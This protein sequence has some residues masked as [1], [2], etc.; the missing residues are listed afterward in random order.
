MWTLKIL[1]EPIRKNRSIGSF[2]FRLFNV[3]GS[4]GLRYTMCKD[5][6]AQIDCRN[7]KCKLYKG[8]GKCSNILPTITLNEDKTFVCWSEQ[9]N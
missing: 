5:Q 1:K 4:V 6:T 7:T 8:A 9:T 3:S 2:L